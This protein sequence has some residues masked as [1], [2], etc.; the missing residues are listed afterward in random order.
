[1]SECMEGM[2]SMMNGPMMGAM[3]AGGGLVLLLV[4]TLLVLSLMA[5]VKFLRSPR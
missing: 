3:M 2:M 5:L 1:M 4:L